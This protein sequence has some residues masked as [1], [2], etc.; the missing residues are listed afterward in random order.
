MRCKGIQEWKVGKVLETG[1][2]DIFQATI[3]ASFL[4]QGSQ[5]C[6]PPVYFTYPSH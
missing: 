5:T 1:G 3:L 6:G 2:C 4:D